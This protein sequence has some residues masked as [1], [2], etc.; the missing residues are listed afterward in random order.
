MRGQGRKWLVGGSRRGDTG[1]QPPPASDYWYY[2]DHTQP[3]TL[4]QDSAGTI[5]ALVGDPVGR[6]NDISSNGWTGTQTT[7]G[8]KATRR[9]TGVEFDG[10]DDF[11]DL[12][13][14]TASP[15]AFTIFVRANALSSSTT[16]RYLWDNQLT[17]LIIAFNSGDGSGKTSYYSGGGWRNSVDNQPTG[18]QILVWNLLDT[19]QGF[20]YRN[21]V[22]IPLSGPGVFAQTG[23]GGTVV[24][25][26]HWTIAGSFLHAR[27][28]CLLIYRRSLSAAEMTNMYQWT[29]SRHGAL[30]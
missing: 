14:M 21:N 22:S 2:I 7:T 11:V 27:L 19:N 28:Q 3:D 1:L 10:N 6:I 15:S 9:D 29:L 30:S 13:G 20:I 16:A 12:T 8:S 26:K 25:G 23:V 4:F 18:D 17:R 5:P 24:L